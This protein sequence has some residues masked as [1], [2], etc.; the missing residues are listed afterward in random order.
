MHR[1]E[2]V[3]GLAHL[4]GPAHLAI[5]VF[6]GVHLGHQAVIRAAL[7]DARNDGGTA[8]VVTFDPH[9]QAVLRPGSEPRQL[10]S[11]AHKLRLLEAL[12]VTHLLVIPFTP[13]FAA[14]HPADFVRALAA[15]ARPLGGI[16]VGHEW[17]FG[18]GRAGNLELLRTL[19][20][21]LG[22]K[23]TGIPEVVALGEPV[24]S[25]RIR[26]LVADGRLA[27][28]GTLLGRT[29]SLLGNVVRGDAVGRKLGFPTANIHTGRE[30]FPPD[31][32]YV[33]TAGTVDGEHLAVVNIGV[34]PTRA[35]AGRQRV[36]EAH[37]L[38]FNGDLYGRELEIVFHRFLRGEQ[39]FE[40]LDAL[41]AQIARDIASARSGAGAKDR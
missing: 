4:R 17:T 29:F 41:R 14:T 18:R 7:A 16:N 39:R 25:T 27:E 21:E 35:E 33:A 20:A 3:P 5:G 15:H 23:V 32:V 11:T 28:A 24:S 38:D 37:L 8:V 34:R 6:D 22:F 40:S 12:G 9:P 30:Q 13:E 2:G 10:T 36:L 26:Q 1:V 19:G 31:G